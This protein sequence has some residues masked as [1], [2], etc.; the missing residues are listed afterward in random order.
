MVDFGYDVA[1]HCDVDPRFGTLA[2]FD[3]LLSQ[4]RRRG[5]K[6]LLDFVLTIRPTNTLGLSRAAL[7]KKITKETGT[8]GAILAKTAALLTIG[9][10]ISAAQLGNGIK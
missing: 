7:R 4:A 10:A 9:S 3:D 5:L 2:D 6:V 8:F 1:D